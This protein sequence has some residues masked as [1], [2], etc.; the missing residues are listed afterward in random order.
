MIVKILI[1]ILV[2]LA[3]FAVIVATRPATFHIERSVVV[4]APPALPFARVNDF[5]RWAEW[6]PYEKLD[7]N[8]KKTYE[9]PAAGVGAT[10]SW[11]GDNKVGEG[12]MTIEK[13]N[14]PSVIGIKLQFFKPFA[15]TNV[16]TFTFAPVADGTK[17]TWAMDGEN[18]FGGKAAGLF[19]DMDKLVGTDFE[20]GLATLKALSEKDGTPAQA[21]K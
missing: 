16:G 20:K 6:S 3:V 10:Y 8:L 17:V 12:K 13:S 19:M 5:H 18:S 4:S 14:E 21:E 7:P 9:G 2:I 15:A 11:V 1:G